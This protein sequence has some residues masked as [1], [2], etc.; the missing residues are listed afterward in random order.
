[1]KCIK[2]LIIILYVQFPPLF[3]ALPF[4]TPFWIR[5]APSCNICLKKK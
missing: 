2:I 4:P 1:M 5:L 3:F